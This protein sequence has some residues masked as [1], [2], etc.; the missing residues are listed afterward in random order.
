MNVKQYTDALQSLAKSC[1]FEESSFSDINLF[2]VLG[3]QRNEVLI[4]RLLKFLLTPNSVEGVGVEPLQL[5]L[6]Q[7]D[8]SRTFTTND[9]QFAS[10]VLEEHTDSN[11]RVDLVIYAGN[12]IY[13]IEV[14]TRLVDQRAQLF[15]YYWHYKEK[16]RDRIDKIYYL[17]P[18]GTAPSASSIQ[19]K[20]EE[21]CRVM[22]TEAVQCL[23]F[24]ED[25]HQW[26]KKLRKNHSDK[27]TYHFLLNQFE[28]VIK[29]MCANSKNQNALYKALGLTDAETF[30]LSDSTRVVLNIMHLDQKEL[31]NTIRDSYLRKHLKMGSPKYKLENTTAETDPDKHS[32]YVIKNTETGKE[33]AWICVE[34]NLYLVSKH[35]IEGLKEGDGFFWCYLKP[36]GY[37]K[38]KFQLRTA[39]PD[40]PDSDIYIGD[41][42]KKIETCL[43]D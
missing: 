16:Y 35:R 24:G 4:C 15:D 2:G 31:W 27:D 1:S 7:I 34:T 43:T 14:K 42:L 17:T 20:S 25:I 6:N 8:C 9:L 26:L 33:I 18:K 23:S 29:V 5:F 11:R 39:N 36:E 38:D 40:I 30:E 12:R 13:P 41:I 10:V 32:L 22:P 37:P 21:D 28:D 19:P 3:I